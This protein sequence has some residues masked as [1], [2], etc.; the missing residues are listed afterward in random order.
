[1]THTHHISGSSRLAAVVS[2]AEVAVCLVT[3]SLWYLGLVVV[4][5][6]QREVRAIRY[7]AR[8]ARLDH[9]ADMRFLRVHGRRR[10]LA[11]QRSRGFWS[12]LFARRLP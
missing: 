9:E 2:L 1:M 11:L 7:H 3:F 12:W 8:L 4:V 6:V 5:R 10:Y